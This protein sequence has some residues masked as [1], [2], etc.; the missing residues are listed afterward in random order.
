[1]TTN[2]NIERK[3]AAIYARVST[4]REDEKEEESLETQEARLRAYLQARGAN[5]E[6][7]VFREDGSSGESLDRPELQ[8]LLAVIRDRGLDTVAVTRID[9]I[10]PSFRD[11]HELDAELES[12]G[13]EIVSLKEGLGTGTPFGRAILKLIL[14]LAELERNQQ[15]LDDPARVGSRP[16]AEDNED[17]ERDGDKE[18]Q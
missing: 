8:L 11:F 9:R 14:V 13:V 15:S 16:A 5:A 1:M 7:L 12:L 17:E 3:R 6:V 18:E 4:H 2:E 10:S